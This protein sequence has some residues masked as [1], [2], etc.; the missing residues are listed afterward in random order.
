MSRTHNPVDKRLKARLRRQRDEHCPL[1]AGALGPINY[2]TDDHLD[3]LAM[4]MD[5]HRADLPRWCEGM[6][7]RPSRAPHMQPCEVRSPAR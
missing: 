6:A 4:Q 5:R 1:C 2:D 7:Q 3:P